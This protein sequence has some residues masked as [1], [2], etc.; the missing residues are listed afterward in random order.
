MK[1][2]IDVDAERTRLT[3]QQDKIKVDLQRSSGKLSNE[4]FVNNAPAEVVTQERKRIAEFEK[5]IA[6][7]NEQLEKLDEL[8]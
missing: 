3:K 2:F 8:A 7:L 1:V 4:K 6:Q 5:A